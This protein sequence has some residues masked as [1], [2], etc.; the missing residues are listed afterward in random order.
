MNWENWNMY[1]YDDEREDGAVGISGKGGTRWLY[2]G[3]RL[4]KSAP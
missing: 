2:L 3:G 4:V 1:I